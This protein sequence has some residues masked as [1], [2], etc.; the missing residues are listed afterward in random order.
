MLNSV[1]PMKGIYTFKFSMVVYNN[2]IFGLFV[3]VVPNLVSLNVF[4]I[5]VF[6]F[7]LL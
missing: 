4:M 3:S 1:L 6:F 5:I 7:C 2:V